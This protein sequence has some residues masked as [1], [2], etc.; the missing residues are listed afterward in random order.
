MGDPLVPPRAELKLNL[1]QA[2][3]IANVGVRRAAAFLKISTTIEATQIPADLS[4]GGTVNFSFWPNPITDETRGDLHNE[5]SAWIVGSC[6]R[7]LDSHFALFLDR[8]RWLIKLSE[9]HGKT[10]HSS[11][12]IERDKKFVQDTNSFRKAEKLAKLIGVD[13]NAAALDSLSRAR[14][15]LTHGIGRVRTRDTHDGK[16]LIVS[17]LAHE[18]VIQDGDRELLFR[19]F[20]ADTYQVTSPDGAKVFARVSERKEKFD[21]GQRVSFSEQDLAEICFFYSQQAA[22]FHDALLKHLE[23]LGILQIKD[24]R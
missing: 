4:L 22:I 14:N 8:I 17:W 16:S 3:E 21:V 23:L 11:T 13:L 20:P 18:L 7:E 5:Y 24:E 15:A 19:D 1:S 10:L 9:L 2:L 6:L 12:I